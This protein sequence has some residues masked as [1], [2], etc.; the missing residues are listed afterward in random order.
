MLLNDVARSERDGG[1]AHLGDRIDVFHIEPLANDTDTDIRLV[2]MICDQQ[3]DA[4]T[5][6]LATEILIDRHA[7]GEV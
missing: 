2:L 6:D 3:F 4:L 7:S 1:V 5:D